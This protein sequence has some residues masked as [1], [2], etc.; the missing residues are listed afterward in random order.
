MKVEAAPGLHRLPYKQFLAITKREQSCLYISNL[1][2]ENTF[3]LTLRMRDIINTPS[4]RKGLLFAWTNMISLYPRIF[5]AKFH[6]FLRRRLVKSLYYFFT[7]IWKRN[8][9]L[10][11]TVTSPVPNEFCDKFDIIDSVVMNVNSLW[12]RQ[13]RQLQTTD[14]SQ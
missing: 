12:Q 13:R 10:L 4:P 5:C 7:S 2:Q 9:S 1:V 11:F 6:L 8:H 3:K 14:I